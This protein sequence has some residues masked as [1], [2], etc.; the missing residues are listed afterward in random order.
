MKEK[1]KN[2]IFRDM[3]VCAVR[4]GSDNIFWLNIQSK[5]CACLLR[6][7]RSYIHTLCSILREKKGLSDG[8][9]FKINLWESGESRRTRPN[10]YFEKWMSLMRK[11]FKILVHG[12]GTSFTVP[13]GN[14]FHTLGIPGRAVRYYWKNTWIDYV[15]AHRSCFT[16]RKHHLPFFLFPANVALTLITVLS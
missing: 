6:K 8:N 9:K 2:I 3:L 15:L 4:N 12:N 14:T 10:N 16:D 5:F 11:T 13:Q 7:G 1:R